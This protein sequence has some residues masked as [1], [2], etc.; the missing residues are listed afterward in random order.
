MKTRNRARAIALYWLPLAV[1]LAVL[2]A[3]ARYT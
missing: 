3:L 2:I 1:V